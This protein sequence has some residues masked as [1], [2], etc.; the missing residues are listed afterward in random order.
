MLFIVHTYL[1]TGSLKL[2]TASVISTTHSNPL[3]LP[4]TS[5][6]STCESGLF[7]IPHISDSIHFVVCSLI[8]FIQL[9]SRNAHPRC[10]GW[11]DSFISMTEQSLCT[12]ARS[13]WSIHCQRTLGL[14]PCLNYC[15]YCC[16]EHGGCKYLVVTVMSFPL[17]KFSD[18]EL[19][20][21]F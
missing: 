19:C 2:L 18:V 20:L 17:D 3:C 13:S 6:F 8:Y 10:R 14:F 4:A 12:H 15:E 16:N 5:L 11:Q 7:K 1:T 9:N 21:T